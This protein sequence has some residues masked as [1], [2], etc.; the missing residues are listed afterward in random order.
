MGS[1]KSLSLIV[2][3]SSMFLLACGTGQFDQAQSYRSADGV[4]TSAEGTFTG[5]IINNDPN[6]S[7]VVQFNSDPTTE[8][9]LIKLDSDDV[10]K[11]S[12]RD[13]SQHVLT[14]ASFAVELPSGA[15]YELPYNAVNLA[16]LLPYGLT[17]KL[18][19]RGSIEGPDGVFQV[20]SNSV[21]VALSST[22]VDIN[23]GLGGS[24]NGL[25]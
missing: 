16:T 20:S 4:E 25:Q 18:S 8:G 11:C 19:C 21:N 22:S 24:V 13:N 2:L 3:I 1:S 6:K 15:L 5:S 12:L 7:L 10:L 14:E 9:Q 17:M 23:G